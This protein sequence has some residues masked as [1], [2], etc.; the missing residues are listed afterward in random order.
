MF[1]FN[2]RTVRYDKSKKLPSGITPKVASS[3]CEKYGGVNCL[4]PVDVNVVRYL[5]E[6]IGG[7]NLIRFVSVEY[8]TEVRKV[9]ERLGIQKLTFHNVW[10]VFSVMLS[11]L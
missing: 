11:M 2:N 3:L 9:Y 10:D 1:T 4:I 6:L 7:E 8:E 5:K